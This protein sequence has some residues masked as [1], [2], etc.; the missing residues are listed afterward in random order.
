MSLNI[1]YFL[2]RKPFLVCERGRK[3]QKGSRPPILKIFLLKFL[4]NVK[5]NLL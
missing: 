1:Y 3:I 5:K 4:L 2:A